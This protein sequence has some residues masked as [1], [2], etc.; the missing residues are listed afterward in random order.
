MAVSLLSAALMIVLLVRRLIVGSE[1][2]GLFTLFAILFFF[3]GLAL[4]GIGLLGEYVGRIYA[5]VRERP[6]YVVEAVLE[7]LAEEAPHV[8]ALPE[9]GRALPQSGTVP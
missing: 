3:I 2:E 6:R 9:S 8:R 4:F 7:D 1:A 5:Q